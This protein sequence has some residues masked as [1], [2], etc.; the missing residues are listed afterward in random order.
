MSRKTSYLLKKQLIHITV[1]I[2][3]IFIFR[4]A[5]RSV[6]GAEQFIAEFTV[7]MIAYFLAYFT[8]EG[9]EAVFGIGQFP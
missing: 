2:C 1:G 3:F 4:A 5:F 9:F 8:I 6:F 7:G